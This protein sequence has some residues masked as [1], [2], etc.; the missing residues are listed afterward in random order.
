MTMFDMLKG[1]GMILVVVLHTLSWTIEENMFAHYSLNF[2]RVFLMPMFFMIS[3]FWLKEKAFIT[4]YV[5]SKKQLLKPYGYAVGVILL[6]SL[7]HRGL[8]GAFAEWYQVFLYPFLLGY[9][10]ENSR[11]SALWFFVALYFGWCLFY[12]TGG[13]K[14]EKIRT[15]VFVLTG[16]IGGILLPF[17][18]PFQ[19]CQGLI[20]SSFVYAGYVVKKKKML[21]LVLRWYSIVLMVLMW[22]A[23]T[24]LCS[25]N[26]AMYDMKAGIFSIAGSIAATFLVL[27]YG[28]LLNHFENRLTDL[29]RMV[30]RYTNI[31][32]CV[33]SVELAVVPWDVMYGLIGDRPLIRFTVVLILRVIFLVVTCSGINL[34]KRKWRKKA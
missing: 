27:Y 3:G 10:G 16:T 33:H 7:I 1:L 23:A 14:D 13:I 6:I 18:L 15:G 5:D 9:S 24:F 22:A 25:M 21:T 20:A 8:K 30:G 26:P 28:V 31:I 34:I 4:G 32:L 17:H 12:L 11:M 2:I 19:I 29:I